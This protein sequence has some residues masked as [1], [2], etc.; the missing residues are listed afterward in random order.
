VLVTTGSLAPICRGH[1]WPPPERGGC[2]RDGGRPG[3]P[4]GAP[5]AV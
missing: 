4:S 3:V 1:G 5:A 2:R